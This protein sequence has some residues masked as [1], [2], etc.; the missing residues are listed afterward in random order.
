MGIGKTYILLKQAE[1]AWLAGY[2]V[3]FVTMEMTIAQIARRFFG[4]QAEVNP[5]LIRK[6]ML[7]YYQHRKLMRYINNMSGVERFHIFA[8]SFA[9]KV[10]DLEVLM[11]ELAP[12]IVY[13][14]SAYRLQPD[15]SSRNSSRLDKVA[16]A[17]DDLKRLTITSNRPIITT[18]QFSRQAGKRGREG[19]LETISFTD[20]LGMHASLV[21]GVKEGAPPNESSQ[22]DFEIYKGREGEGG[23]FTIN[24]KFK[25]IDFSE[26]PKEPQQAQSAQPANMDWMA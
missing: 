6:G 19:S 7:D 17:F 26:V 10:S 22:R 12:D 20:A 8:G 3:L 9:K 2:N 21:F 4:I 5:D 11:H 13:I 23:V 1:A 14:D 16:G 25:P 24:F 18:S 15:A